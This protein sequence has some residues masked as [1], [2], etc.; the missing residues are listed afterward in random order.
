MVWSEPLSHLKFGTASF[1]FASF[2]FAQDR[3]DRLGT[4]PTGSFVTPRYGPFG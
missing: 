4:F 2:D 1:G 3:Q